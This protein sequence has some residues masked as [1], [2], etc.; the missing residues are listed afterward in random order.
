MV[1]KRDPPRDCRPPPGKPW[2]RPA[3]TSR[4]SGAHPSRGRSRTAAERSVRPRTSA[5]S[6]TAPFAR[7]DGPLKRSPRSCIPGSAL[8]EALRPRLEAEVPAFLAAVVFAIVS[9]T[10]DDSAFG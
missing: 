2:V 7:P 4:S 8:P 6:T 10:V 9:L 5:A 1:M 3:A